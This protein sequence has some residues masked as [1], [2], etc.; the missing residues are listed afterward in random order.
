MSP[1]NSSRHRWA[2][3]VLTWERALHPRLFRLLLRLTWPW[4]RDADGYLAQAYGPIEMRFDLRDSAERQGY[5]GTYDPPQLALV[6][7]FC[8]PGFTVVD[9]GANVG[10]IAAT[11]AACVG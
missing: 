6:R 4:L 8:E 7:R 10:I 1:A 11:A 2:R 3:R 9:V 5:L